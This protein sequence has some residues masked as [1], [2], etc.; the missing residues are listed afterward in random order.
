MGLEVLLVLSFG[1]VSLVLILVVLWPEKPAKSQRLSTSY[2]ADELRV[3]HKLR[4]EGKMSEQEFEA[5]KK[6]LLQK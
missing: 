3:L 5:E 2:V 4:N 1:I 6:R